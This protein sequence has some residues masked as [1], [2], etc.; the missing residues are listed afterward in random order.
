MK[1]RMKHLSVLGHGGFRKLAYLEWGSESAT[2][3]IICVHGVSR[4][5]RDFDALAC[6][7]AKENRVVVPDLPGKPQ[8]AGSRRLR[9]APTQASLS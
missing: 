8:S 5:G 2:R 9:A 1:P 6:V 3:T 4:S 7:L